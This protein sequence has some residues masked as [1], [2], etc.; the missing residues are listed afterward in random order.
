MEKEFEEIEA[1]NDWHIYYQEIRNETCYDYLTKDAKKK[2][3][4][5]LNR[6]RDVTPCKSIVVTCLVSFISFNR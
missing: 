1:R 6:Y 5:D 3:N 2:E 4:R